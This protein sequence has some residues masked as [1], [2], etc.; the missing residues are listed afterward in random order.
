MFAASKEGHKAQPVERHWLEDFIEAG[1]FFGLTTNSD[2]AV[3]MEAIH[4]EIFGE[5]I[6][7]KR[8]GAKPVWAPDLIDYEKYEEPTVARVRGKS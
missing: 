6:E 7:A 2:I 8:R 5:S 3:L 4:L 1:V